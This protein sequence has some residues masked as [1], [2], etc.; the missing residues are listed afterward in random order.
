VLAVS[1][2]TDEADA[3]AIANDSD[4]GL[5]GTVWTTDPDRGMAVAR[6]VET[7]T[8]GVNTCLP[9]PSRPSAG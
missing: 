9:D 7:A 3:V 1:P 5:G 6:R 4:F 2:Y 8:I